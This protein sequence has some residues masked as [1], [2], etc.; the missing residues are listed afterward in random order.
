MRDN[1]RFM[2]RNQSELTRML[3]LAERDVIDLTGRQLAKLRDDNQLMITQLRDWYGNAADNERTLTFLHQLSLK[4]LSASPKKG[5]TARILAT[6]AKKT[7][8]SKFCKL[9]ETKKS[10]VKISA[11]DKK[12]LDESL[13][14]V[15]TERPMKSLVPVLGN[16]KWKAYLNIP[17]YNRTLR[18]V[19]VLA[20]DRA[21]DFPRSARSDY[22]QRM[23]EIIAVSLQRE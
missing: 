13:G 23:A 2:R 9:F 3:R 22:A 4:L 16:K 14:V 1:P 6:E 21:R 19:I 17:V 5:Q 18:A 12:R 10:D 20:T 11:A 15:R 8:G 7:L